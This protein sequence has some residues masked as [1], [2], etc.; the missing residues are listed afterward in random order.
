[1]SAYGVL[2]ISALQPC[3]SSFGSV[4][5][6]SFLHFVRALLDVEAYRLAD[7]LFENLKIPVLS[8]N[9]D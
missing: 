4:A 2:A 7:W 6:I 1:M 8:Q 3:A 5:P 9:S